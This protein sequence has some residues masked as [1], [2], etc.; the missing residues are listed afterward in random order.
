MG[1]PTA[2]PIKAGTTELPSLWDAVASGAAVV[3]ITFTTGE[4]EL[5]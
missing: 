1:L 4:R 5:L 3:D 2:T